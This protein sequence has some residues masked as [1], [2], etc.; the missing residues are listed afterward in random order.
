MHP[1]DLRLWR[2]FQARRSAA[3]RNTLIERYRDIP[4]RYAERLATQVP[5][6][7]EFGDLESAGVFGLMDAIDAFDLSRGIKFETYCVRRVRGAMLDALRAQDWI[8]RLE[9]ARTRRINTAAESLWIKLGRHPTVKEIAAECGMS[10]AE[11][12][13]RTATNQPGFVS[14]SKAM[15]DADDGG[16]CDRT[17]FASPVHR[18]DLL[19]DQTAEQPTDRMHSS[20]MLRIAMRGLSDTE[21]LLIIGYYY[22][23]HTMKRI[24]SDLGLSESRISQLH[25]AIIERLGKRLRPCREEFT[26]LGRV[27]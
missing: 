23:H 2:K 16:S 10:E 14:L 6:V 3:N 20:D 11:V 5:P 19:A 15:Y 4:K 22:Q 18:C 1:A 12:E 9:R 27:A 25:T 7:I 26:P 17:E 13:R 24:G 21:R 8:P